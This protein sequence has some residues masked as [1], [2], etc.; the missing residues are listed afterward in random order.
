MDKDTDLVTKVA[1]AGIAFAASWVVQKLI[2]AAWRGA[3]GHQPPADDD[4]GAGLV[5]I[6]LAAAI[7]GA[8]VA[9]ARRFA[10]RSTAKYISPKIAK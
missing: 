4:D 9:L 1:G 8:A 2:G 3:T 7:T 10:A 5:E 6:L